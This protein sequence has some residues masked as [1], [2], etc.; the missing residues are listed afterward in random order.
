M[1]ELPHSVHQSL[2]RRG[3]ILHSEIF[4]DIDHGKFFAVIG[5]SGEMVAGF[6]FINS[7]IHPVIQR[8]PEQFA[9]QY[10]LRRQYYRF[11]KYDSFLCATSI[12]KVPVSK[13][14]TS[15]SSGQTIYAGELTEDDLA[16][17]LNACRNSKLFSP[18]EKRKFLY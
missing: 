13:L 5:I 18:A 4:D 10:V 9:M 7:R 2:I 15:I 11:L 8:R 1:M 3:T 12:Q 17:V 16:A 6:F 14:T